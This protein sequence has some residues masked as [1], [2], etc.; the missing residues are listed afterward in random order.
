MH[1][2]Q[3]VRSLCLLF[4]LVR[5]H[6]IS[7]RWSNKLAIVIKLSRVS[8]VNDGYREK[9]TN[10]RRHDLLANIKVH[11]QKH[12][13]IRYDVDPNFENGKPRNEKE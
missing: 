6:K 10:I 2:K 12:D 8:C 3:T 9:N 1:D 4:T 7:S 13:H 11:E 5:D